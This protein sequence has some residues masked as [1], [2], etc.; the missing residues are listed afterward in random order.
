MSRDEHRQ[1]KLLTRLREARLASAN[2]ALVEARRAAEEADAQL[3]A[4]EAEANGADARLLRHRGGLAADPL[5]P[6]A[7]LALVDRSLFLQAVARSASNDAAEALRLCEQA[8][9]ER[10]RAMI[11]ARARRDLMADHARGLGR[12]AATQRE[13]RSQAE[14]QERRTRV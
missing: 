5:D 8:E 3:R 10:R 11:L 7:Q 13:E 14:A 9:Q 12:R 1:A 4:A 6:P 2:R